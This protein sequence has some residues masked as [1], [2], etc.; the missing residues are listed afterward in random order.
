MRRD[1]KTC[2]FAAIYTKEYRES[3]NEE[4]ASLI[5]ELEVIGRCR[6]CPPNKD[7]MFGEIREGYWCGE[8]K[9]KSP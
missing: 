8:Y 1:C 7:G 5:A 9:P 3:W 2:D 6:R 4:Y